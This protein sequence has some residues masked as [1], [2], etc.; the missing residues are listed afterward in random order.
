MQYELN[1]AKLATIS[2]D[3]E[4]IL[5]AGNINIS[6]ISLVATTFFDQR[7]PVTLC[8]LRL[9][10]LPHIEVKSRDDGHMLLMPGSKFLRNDEHLSKNAKITKAFIRFIMQ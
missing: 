8:N 5:N 4:S 3:L 9:K 10:V 2:G 1:L 7:S 6:H